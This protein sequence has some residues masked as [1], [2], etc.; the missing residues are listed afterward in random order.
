MKI[1]VHKI[2]IMYVISQPV[3]RGDYRVGYCEIRGY[4]DTSNNI[5]KTAEYLSINKW[6]SISRSTIIT[7]V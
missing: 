4:N 6:V 7:I 2:C 5:L 3:S 1:K